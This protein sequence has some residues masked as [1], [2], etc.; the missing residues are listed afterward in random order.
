MFSSKRSRLYFF[1][2]VHN[3]LIV[4]VL[5]NRRHQT[6][7]LIILKTSLLF[8][9]CKRTR[10]CFVWWV[11]IFR[12]RR[13]WAVSDILVWP[14]YISY[15]LFRS[16]SNWFYVQ[17]FWI[18]LSALFQLFNILTSVNFARCSIFNW[19]FVW[20]SGFCDV[21]SIGMDEL[22]APSVLYFYSSFIFTCFINLLFPKEEWIILFVY[23]ISLRK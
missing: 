4:N 10:R 15:V 13:D 19:V 9:Q 16:T 11:E 7:K 21:E 20:F 23:V 5:M 2:H 6:R 8:V 18:I 22:T 1:P 3:F 17:S 14:I 12:S